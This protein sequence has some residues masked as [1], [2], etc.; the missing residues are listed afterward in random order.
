VKHGI[1][2]VEDPGHT[3]LLFGAKYALEKFLGEGL[4]RKFIPVAMDSGQV[5]LIRR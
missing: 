1:L 3:P 5:F 2:V 4:G